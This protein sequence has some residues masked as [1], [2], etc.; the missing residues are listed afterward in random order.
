MATASSF[1]QSS[2]VCPFYR[3]DDGRQAITCEGILPKSSCT[4]RFARRHEW[5]EW[6]QARCCQGWQ[7]CPY[8]VLA[9]LKWEDQEGM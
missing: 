8:A 5:A 9:G 7:Q 2:V 1:I 6:V 3:K 4:L